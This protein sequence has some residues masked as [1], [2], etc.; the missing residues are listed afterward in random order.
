MGEGVGEVK[1]AS[2][3]L[4]VTAFLTAGYFLFTAGHPIAASWCIAGAILEAALSA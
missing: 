4:V 3:V 1:D 2:K